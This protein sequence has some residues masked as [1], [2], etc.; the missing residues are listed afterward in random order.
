MAYK[1]HYFDKK[2]QM[3]N[4]QCGRETDGYYA[5]YYTT[6]KKQKVTCLSCLHSHRAYQKRK[7]ADAP[8][9]ADGRVDE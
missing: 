7:E 6:P 5:V 3:I 4:T 2:T 9:E 8:G 1:M